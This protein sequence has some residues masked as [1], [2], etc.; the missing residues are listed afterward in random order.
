MYFYC[1][2]IPPLA[3]TDRILLFSIMAEE[4]LVEYLSRDRCRGGDVNR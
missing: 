4:N 1:V 3:I 2:I